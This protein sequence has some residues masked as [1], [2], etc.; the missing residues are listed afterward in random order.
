VATLLGAALLLPP[1]VVCYYFLCVP[2]RRW[3]FTW[4]GAAAAGALA[5][6][7]LLAWAG[8]GA[9]GG[10]DPKFGN[11]ARTL[12][13]SEW[14]AY[15]LVDLPLALR[16][17]LLAAAVAFSRVLTE[18]VGMLAME[19]LEAARLLG[20]SNLFPGTIAA[21]DPGHNSSRL[22]LERFSLTGP[23][24]RG[25]FRGDRVWVA[26]RPENVSVHSGDAEAGAGLIG[27]ELLRASHRWRWVRLEFS[28]GIFADL[29]RDEFARRKDNENWKVE[30]PP[31]ALR[32]F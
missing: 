14:R 11:A 3:T 26:I 20:I 32:V 4:Q 5:A 17:I 9:F 13:A 21:L 25:H 7:P 27:V 16:P 30:F 29:P 2:G 23:Y 15:W 24:I 22:E 12:G 10:L 1:P 8:R 31:E 28:H 18:T 6:V 19:S